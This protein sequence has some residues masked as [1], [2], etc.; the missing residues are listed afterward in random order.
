LGNETKNAAGTDTTL[1]GNYITV[2]KK[3]SDGSWKYVSDAG[4]NTPDPYKK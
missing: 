1:F 2:W 3:Q 4:S